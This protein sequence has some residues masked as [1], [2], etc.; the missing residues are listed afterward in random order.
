MA[1]CSNAFECQEIVNFLMENYTQSCIQAIL[2]PQQLTKLTSSKFGG[3]P[4]WDLKRP[5]PCNDQQ[6]PLILI[7]QINCADLP[8]HD[9]LPLSGIIQFYCENSL[10]PQISKVVYFKE[11]NL[12]ITEI[13]VQKYIARTTRRF[14]KT[15]RDVIWGCS[16][17]S[18]TLKNSLPVH[19]DGDLYNN[20][21][22]DAAQSCLNR[23]LSDT[24][25]EMLKLEV[26]SYLPEEL[27]FSQKAPVSPLAQG[28]MQLLGFPMRGDHFEPLDT[29]LLFQIRNFNLQN[30]K[31]QRV[32]GLDLGKQAELYYTIDSCSLEDGDYNCAYLTYVDADSDN[33]HLR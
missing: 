31:G 28:Q 18:F 20:M 15:G 14:F 2:T 8:E 6:E 29:T 21:L 5:F 7:A 33:V 16:G 13:E 3:V 30:T 10:N 4:Y 12:K 22:Q 9:Y 1:V 32:C 26:D 27:K 17:L 23:H 24:A 11:I 19:L 25:I